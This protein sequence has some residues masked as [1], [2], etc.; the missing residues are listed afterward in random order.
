M[1]RPSRSSS[2][3]PPPPTGVRFH[4]D[5]VQTHGGN[6]YELNAMAY[7]HSANCGQKSYAVTGW[8]EYTRYD[9]EDVAEA[10]RR[11]EGVYDLSRGTDRVTGAFSAP[12][13]YGTPAGGKA[14]CLSV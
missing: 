12:R 14:A 2:P 7:V 1:P 6:L 13:V 10:D 9:G 11:V 5:Q 8:V 4:H 3:T